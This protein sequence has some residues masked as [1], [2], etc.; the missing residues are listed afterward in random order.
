MGHL[1]QVKSLFTHHIQTTGAPRHSLMHANT[2]HR[3]MLAT[4]AYAR[5]VHRFGNPHCVSD[6][7]HVCIQ[8]LCHH[9]GITKQA[10]Y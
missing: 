8:S 4:R 10:F 1:S 7:I 5:T 3:P 6:S 9:Y 2:A